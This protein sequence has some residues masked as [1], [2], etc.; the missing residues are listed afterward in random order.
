M[1]SY[2]AGFVL[3]R[4]LGSSQNDGGAQGTD[5]RGDQRF[6]ALHMSI[7]PEVVYS[8]HRVLKGRPS[9]MAT[10]SVG[11]SSLGRDIWKSLEKEN[12]S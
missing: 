5:A 3:N 11:G 4:H 9:L 10:G 2:L 6:E 8:A 12:R 1:R 7:G